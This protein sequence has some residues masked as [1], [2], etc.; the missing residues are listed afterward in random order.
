MG[1]HNHEVFT[2]LLGLSDVEIAALDE[3]EVFA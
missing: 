2:T 1:E 3:D